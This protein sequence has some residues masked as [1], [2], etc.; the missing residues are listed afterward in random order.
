[1]IEILHF[2]SAKADSVP[3]LI[4]LNDRFVNFY[5]GKLLDFYLRSSTKLG[6]R[7]LR[8]QDL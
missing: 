7:S 3:S 5:T 8:L 1:M 4:F 6:F 2:D